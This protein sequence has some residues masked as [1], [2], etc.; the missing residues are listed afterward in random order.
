MRPL[1]VVTAVFALCACD[2]PASLPNESSDKVHSESI[3][4]QSESLADQ[5]LLRVCKAGAAF[6]GGRNVEG[7]DAKVTGDQQVR[8]SYTRDDGKAFAYDCMIDGNTAR[9]RMID[10]A[11]PGTGPGAWSGKGSHT[12]FKLNSNSVEFTDDFLD[13]SADT[14]TIPI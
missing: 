3:N 5:D 2:N 14:K 9:F 1:L 13:G 11:G 8:L 7:I 12:T 10:E 6:R 4:Q